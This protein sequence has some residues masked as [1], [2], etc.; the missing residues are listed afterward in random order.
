[1]KPN[2]LAAVSAAFLAVGTLLP[3]RAQ[4]QTGSTIPSIPSGVMTAF[5]TVVQT[6]AKPTLTWSI[7]YPAMIGIPGGGGGNGNG[8]GGGNNGSVGIVTVSPPGTLTPSTTVYATVQV[9]GTG[10]TACDTTR[11]A[12][13]HFSDARVSFNGG[14]YQQ[15]FYGT[16]AQVLPSKQVYI[17]KLL[18]NQTLDF[19]GRYVKDG[20]YSPFYT[21]RSA[22]FQVVALVNGQ[23]PPT[24]SPLHLSSSLA[25]YL[26]PYLDST[27]KVKIGPLS[28]LIVMELGQTNRSSRCFDL[29]DQVLLVTFSTKHPN[30]GHGN[31][32]DGVDSSNPGNGKGGPNGMVDPSGGFDDEIR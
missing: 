11:D 18:A 15:L 6:G 7:L 2:Q 1:M 23:T 28:V 19:G 25:S 24:S 4:A 9:V 31:N 5:P 32:L 29:Q 14:A 20:V 17:K 22:N 27:G 12:L 16:Q 30:N 3:S 21:T 8:S 10:I 26:R 13:T